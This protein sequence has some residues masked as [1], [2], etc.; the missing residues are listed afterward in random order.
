MQ[1]REPEGVR[2]S[3]RKRMWMKNGFRPFLRYKNIK[4]EAAEQILKD[5]ACHTISSQD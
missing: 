3:K 1:S 5:T 2:D 4:E